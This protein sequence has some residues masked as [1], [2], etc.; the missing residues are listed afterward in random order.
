MHADYTR[1]FFLSRKKGQVCVC[2]LVREEGR[3]ASVC[4]HAVGECFQS[5]LSHKHGLCVSAVLNSRHTALK[6]R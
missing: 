1:L 4:V 6:I 5:S 3:F 2:V